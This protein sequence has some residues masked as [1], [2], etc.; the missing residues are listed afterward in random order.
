MSLDEFLGRGSSI[1]KLYSGDCKVF[2]GGRDKCLQEVRN[3]G[4]GKLTAVKYP[5]ILDAR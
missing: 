5:E 2:D 3:G 1:K 4:L